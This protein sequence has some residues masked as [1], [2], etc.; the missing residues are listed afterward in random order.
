MD[1][2]IHSVLVGKVNSALVGNRSEYHSRFFQR[3][4]TFFK[5]ACNAAKSHDKKINKK[6]EGKEN[7]T[8]EMKW[9]KMKGPLLLKLKVKF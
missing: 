8:E 3:K 7:I 1:N 9:L 4:K 6:K 2:L 5:S